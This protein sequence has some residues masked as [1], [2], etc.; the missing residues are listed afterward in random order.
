MVWEILILS[1]K[2]DALC[3][4]NDEDLTEINNYATAYLL[5]IYSVFRSFVEDEDQKNYPRAFLLM[6][7]RVFLSNRTS[8]TDMVRTI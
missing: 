4:L 2:I 5:N 3:E 8:L 1:V 7:R 6:Y